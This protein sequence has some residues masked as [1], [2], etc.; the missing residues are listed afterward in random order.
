MLWLC[1]CFP[2][3][4]FDA[5]SLDDNALT[6]VTFSNGRT[7]RVLIASEAAQ[8]LKITDGMDFATASTLCADIQGVDR[9]TQAERKALDRL[10]AWAYQWSSAVTLQ[11]ANPRSSTECSMVWLEIA[12]SFKLFGG[13]D[14]LLKRV[15]AE[16]KE[17]RY[18][19][20]L[21]VAC[22]LEGAALLARARRRIVAHTPAALRRQIAPLPIRSLALDD[23]VLYELHQAGIR[24]V[25]AF[26]GLPRDAIARRFG[27]KVVDYLDRLLGAAADPRPLFQMPK[28][29][30]ARCELGA[31]VIDTEALLFPLKRMLQELQGYL[32]AID[33]GVQHFLLHLQH[34]QTA[35]RIAIGLSAPERR[36][37]L[38]FAVVRERLERLTLTEPA[39]EIRLQADHFTAPA[40]RQTAI[41]AE[42]QEHPEEFQHVFDKLTARLGANAIHHYELKADYRP[43]K[44]WRVAESTTSR[45]PIPPPQSTLTHGERIAS[46]WWDGG[47]IARDYYFLRAANGAGFWVFRDERNEWFVH[48]VCG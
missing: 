18:A 25:K 30:R 22:S 33:G 17:L 16:L 42:A 11:A 13:R 12:A 29:Y 45:A 35:T 27:P 4:P 28:K 24:T 5:L 41:F 43:E 3:L 20:R 38:F 1:I 8:R 14:A 47:D 31:E 6:V 37:D 23:S 36:A 39:L 26:I 10:A 9:N 7:R 15:E 34:R 44:A 19:Y 32:R 48:G 2:R 46:G 21:G 40:V